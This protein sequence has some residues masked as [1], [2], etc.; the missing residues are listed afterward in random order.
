[1]PYVGT[2]CGWRP[3]FQ[4][5]LGRLGA[6]KH[7]NFFKGQW[8]TTARRTYVYVEIRARKPRRGKR[9][10]PAS[11]VKDEVRGW[12]VLRQ[13]YSPEPRIC[14]VYAYWGIGPISA[15]QQAHGVDHEFHYVVDSFLWSSNQLYITCAYRYGYHDLAFKEC[16]SVLCWSSVTVSFTRWPTPHSLHPELVRGDSNSSDEPKLR[17]CYRRAESGSSK[18]GSCRVSVRC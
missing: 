8:Q 5:W 17:Q 6:R 13:L 1:M 9:H 2:R 16:L 18:H 4:S 15:A 3:S 10:I 11:F 12:L 14:P 7:E